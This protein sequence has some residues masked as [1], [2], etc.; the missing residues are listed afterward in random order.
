MSDTKSAAAPNYQTQKMSGPSADYDQEKQSITGSKIA[1]RLDTRDNAMQEDTA[2]LR[3]KRGSDIPAP[4]DFAKSS[5]DM[6]AQKESAKSSSAAVIAPNNVVNNNNSTQV[7]SM[8]PGN[9]DKSF[10]NLSSVPV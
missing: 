4:S 2:S 3:R 6:V 1:S 8:E 10:L 5:A 7:M 9:P